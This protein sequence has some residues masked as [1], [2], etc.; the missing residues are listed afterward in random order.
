MNFIRHW[1]A[2]HFSDPHVV[3]LAILLL[4]G[5]GVVMWM[6]NYLAPVI[7]AVIIAYLLEGP[8]GYL[9]YHRIPRLVASVIVFSLFMAFVM[10]LLFGV[11][12]LIWR[13]AT[14]LIQ[15]FPVMLA[16]GQ[17]ALLNLP[18]QYPNLFSEEQVR[19]LVTVIRARVGEF[20]QQVLSV[21]LASVVGILAALVYLILVPLMVFFFL[22]DKARMQQWAKG[23]LPDSRRL[24]AQVWHE[25]DAQIG[26]YV[27]GKVIEILIVWFVSYVTFKFL[28][29]NFAMLL[30]VLV[31]LSV[32]IPYV[33]AVVVTVPVTLIAFFQW[34]L[35]SD[36]YWLVGSY[37]FIQFLDGNLLVPLLF[38]EVVN[39]HPVAIIAAV[40]VFGG[41]WGFWGVFFAI[42]L[43]T[44]VQAVLRA[45]PALDELDEQQ[46]ALATPDGEP[47]G[48]SDD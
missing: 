11:M 45:W 21:S 39:L 36:F 19:D 35:T 47:P 18:E 1:F 8:V 40:L 14:A 30:S 12:P 6:G 41:L 3:G 7:A 16:K 25:V 28:G 42:P 22:K 48:T 2:R 34:G 37:L 20:G 23:F 17:E 31:G 5:F 29:L 38:S 26:N 9:Q 24:S 4:V 46:P 10:V 44:L 13:Q 33:G 15:Q 27:R 32:L 43:A